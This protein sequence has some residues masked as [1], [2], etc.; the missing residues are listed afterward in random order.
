MLC[1]Q[2]LIAAAERRS[3]CLCMPLFT[4]T[5]AACQPPCCAA[6]SPSR[7]PQLP[8]P[9]MRSNGPGLE[10]F[11]SVSLVTLLCRAA[12]LAWFDSDASRA[13]VDECKGLMDR[14]S[15][16]GWAMAELPSSSGSRG[17]C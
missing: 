9:P 8:P 15:P 13:L 3:G 14:G 10:H 17:A 1:Q 5:H 6:G 7:P 11:A 2:R 12:K 4:P 16:G